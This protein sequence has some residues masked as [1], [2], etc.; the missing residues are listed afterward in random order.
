MMF[1]ERGS[2]NKFFAFNLNVDESTAGVDIT[3]QEPK[4]P[5]IMVKYT[6]NFKDEI[7]EISLKFKDDT[8]IKIAGEHLKIFPKDIDKHRAITRY[9]NESKPEYFVITSKSQRPLKA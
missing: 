8:R 9:L 4:L 6:N 3:T 1:G 2:T 7:A 5:P